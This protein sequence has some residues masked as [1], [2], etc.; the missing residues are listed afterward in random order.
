M[1]IANR[2][3]PGLLIAALSVI[4]AACQ[5]MGTRRPQAHAMPMLAPVQELPEK[6]PRLGQMRREWVETIH[7]SAPDVDWRREDGRALAQLMTQRQAR[8]LATA[9]KGRAEFQ[10]EG[11][12]LGD[13]RI[14]RWFERGSGNQAGR[15]LATDYDPATGRILTYAHGGQ[16]WRA[17]RSLLDWTSL[18]DAAQFV[19]R[20]TS[21]FM[22]RLPGTP[23]R[24]VIASD[25]PNGMFFSDDLGQNWTA[26]QGFPGSNAWYVTGLAVRAGGNELYLSRNY[27][28]FDSQS[29]R[30]KLFA[31]SNRGASFA[32][33]GFVGTRDQVSLFSPRYD[34]SEV[35]LLNGTQ[36]SR[37]VAGTQQVQALS[38]VPLNIAIGGR[39]VLL[40]GGVSNSGEVFL[41]A[42]YA[43]GQT[44]GST[45]LYRSLDGGLSWTSLSDAPTGAFSQ[46]SMVSSSRNPDQVFVGGIDLYRSL[47]GGQSWQ[48]VNSWTEYYSRPQDR[49]H[50]DLPE[51]SPFLEQDGTERFF[52]STDGGLYTSTDA[53]LSV[54]NLS[55]NGLNVSQYYGSYTRR[56]AP[57]HLLLGSQDQGYQK[58]LDP[59][60]GGILYPFQEVSGD[61]AHLVSSDG[62]GN[63]WFTYPGSAWLDRATGAA[64]TQSQ[65]A[66]W[67]FA[68]NNFSGWLFLPPMLADP[69]DPTAALLG[70]GRIGAG[71]S[72]RVIRL[73]WNGSSITA[74]ASAQ[75]FGSV[76]T[77]LAAD[78]LVV[79]RLYAVT[80]ARQ[81]W[82]SNDGGTNWS[83]LASNLPTHAFFYGQR[84]LSDPV[85][86]NRLYVA[87]AGYSSPGVLVSND[88][89]ATFSPMTTGL[90]NTLVYDLAI[91]PDGDWLFAATEL[92][93]FLY[94]QSSQ[95]WLDIGA[96]GGPAQIYWHVD[97]VPALQTAR[98]STYGRGIWDFQIVGDAI[99]G[100]DF[101]P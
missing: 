101:G 29:W 50:A 75:D 91:S 36:L 72:H 12:D 57:H 61:F 1:H 3:L 9:D 83:Q 15:V 92:G 32:D 54:Q 45:R 52:I 79:G 76:I 5:G 39:S 55:L 86:P 35:Y 25:R 94:E 8:R 62:G 23:E 63:L 42:A 51:L 38:K 26:A 80:S 74:T 65:L 27:Y 69:Q 64:G 19:P 96:A 70:G 98:F 48:R 49:L 20:A 37:I 77:A 60:V 4:L 84:I 93:A 85:V 28:D 6:D 24:L 34:S 44:S 30:P 14:G 87:G 88:G 40:S 67:G 73:Q 53:L 95:S 13:G 99:F 68:P 59:P 11:V 46:N 41:F 47:N 100:D 43:N 82:R 7:R 97:F 90:P 31:S 10:L 16:I 33:L 58:A 78:A 22:R 71:E 89:G 2:V 66:S 81:L 56:E 18:N 21:G 17:Q